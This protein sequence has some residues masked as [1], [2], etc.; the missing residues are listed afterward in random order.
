MYSS[1][2]DSLYGKGIKVQREIVT[3]EDLA[4]ALFDCKMAGNRLIFKMLSDGSCGI[5]NENEDY[6][7][8]T[9]YDIIPQRRGSINPPVKIIFE[10]GKVPPVPVMGFRR[11]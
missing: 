4:N 1:R 6:P 7:S 3:I 8:L 5:Y 2:A 9:S 11:G 10:D